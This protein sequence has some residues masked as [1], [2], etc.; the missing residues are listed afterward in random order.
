MSVHYQ[1]FENHFVPR[2]KNKYFAPHRKNKKKSNIGVVFPFFNEEV[3]ELTRSFRSIY[4]QQVQCEDSLKTEFYYVAVMDG[5]EKA[6]DSVKEYIL[7]L[8]P[9][10]ENGWLKYIE[11]ADG[12][13]SEIGTLILQKVDDDK[14]FTTISVEKDVDLKLAIV[15]KKDNRRKANSHEWFF[16]SFAVEYDV[17]YAFA[18]DCGTLYDDNCLYNLI[19]YLDKHSDVA[20]VTGRQRVMSADMQEVDNGGL[21]AMWYRASQAYDYEAS[22]SSFQGAFSLIGFLPV[23]PGPCGL[24]RM[25]DMRPALDYYFEIIN[26]EKEEIGLLLGN[27]LIAED[28]ILS[29][30]AVF[31]TGKISKWVPASVFYFEAE[32]LSVNFIT[33]RR[34]WING[35]FAGYI[36][37][38]FNIN[39]VIWKSSHSTL[40]KIAS[41][42]LIILQCISFVI[43][44]FTPAI[45]TSLIYNTIHIFDIY[46]LRYVDIVISISYGGLYIIFTIFHYCYKFVPWLYHFILFINAIMFIFIAITLIAN[47]LIADGLV[48]VSTIIILFTPFILSLVHSFD[49]FI[50]MVF[51]F[52]PFMFFLPTFIAWFSAYSISHIWD[53]SWGNRPSDVHGSAKENEKNRKKNEKCKKPKKKENNKI[54]ANDQIEIVEYYED[55][56]ENEHTIIKEG[57]CENNKEKNEKKGLCEG[58]ESEIDYNH[59]ISISLM[60]SNVP[61]QNKEERMKRNMKSSGRNIILLCVVANIIVFIY[62]SKLDSNDMIRLSLFMFIPTLIQQ[63]LSLLYF[64]FSSDHLLSSTLH[65]VSKRTKRIA[66]VVLITTTIIILVTSLVSS[67]WLTTSKDVIEAYNFT[68]TDYM[69]K[70]QLY[71]NMCD[72]ELHQFNAFWTEVEH[73][74]YDYKS[75]VFIY[76]TETLNILETY[77]NETTIFE[78]FNTLG[79]VT[80]DNPVRRTFLDY[81][82]NYSKI[83]KNGELVRIKKEIYALTAN[84]MQ[85]MTFYYDEFPWLNIAVF[86]YEKIITKVVN[87]TYEILNK[88]GHVD[89]QYGILFIDFKY[90]GNADYKNETIFWGDQSLYDWPNLSWTIS[91]FTL[92]ISLLFTILIFISVL[93]STCMKDK[94]RI[95]DSTIMYLWMAFITLISSVISFQIGLKDMNSYLLGWWHPY[96]KEN[97]LAMNLCEFSYYFDTG[98]CSISYSYILIIVAIIPLNLSYNIFKFTIK[99]NKRKSVLDEYDDVEMN[100]YSESFSDYKEPKEHRIVIKIPQEMQYEHSETRM[101][102]TPVRANNILN[103]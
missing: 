101:S 87:T 50:M 26:V 86:K 58:E 34:R 29:Y 9:S 2:D 4:R 6:A 21:L 99:K 84:T 90:Y 36:Y 42:L 73:C 44:I 35:S 82:Y 70:H 11:H 83:Y 10:D 91:L 89:L 22:I 25:A 75:D 72:K 38:L 65:K 102:N 19:D 94:S 79:Y 47:F 20:V 53:L 30:A 48:F 76:P 64:T 18:T 5:W 60:E 66:G 8:F 51:N 63:F 56:E 32:T 43:S 93:Y 1:Y 100:S 92:L 85:Y 40:F 74:Y 96:Y 37:L 28:R 68:A 14:Q 3:Y 55:V 78:T 31:K 33:Q 69:H 45:F 71:N 98:E 77:N 12:D 24:Y 95:K 41:I 59:E 23:I 13:R 88:T 57:M 52:I 97:N 16:N 54:D 67:A 15:I 7:K 46:Y 81:Y 39:D 62:F 61:V 49:V 80:S 27:L 17:T 103:N